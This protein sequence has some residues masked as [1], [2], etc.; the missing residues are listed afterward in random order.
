M[1]EEPKGMQ[2]SIGL[3]TDIWFGA[4]WGGYQRGGGFGDQEILAEG[5]EERVTGEHEGV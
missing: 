5:A 3:E 1:G 2:V 4:E